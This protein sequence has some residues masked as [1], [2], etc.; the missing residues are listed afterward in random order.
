LGGILGLTRYADSVY[1]ET[2]FGAGPALRYYPGSR[3]S[4]LLPYLGGS[5]RC[6]G[7]W[8][9][10]RGPT[11]PAF[12]FHRHDTMFTWE[13]TAGLAVLSSR[14]VG[15]VGE[16]YYSPTHYLTDV[17]GTTTRTRGGQ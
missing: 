11:P 1:L 16:G 3:H 6:E 2:V 10:S 7:G 9:H 12:A 13:G 15:L 14:Q 8:S 17:E 4:R 5:L